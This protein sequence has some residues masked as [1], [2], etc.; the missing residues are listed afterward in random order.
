MDQSHSWSRISSLVSLSFVSPFYTN[1]A[2]DDLRLHFIV[3]L[4]RF[5]L[6]R[7]CL[8]ARQFQPTWRQL[9]ALA[10]VVV[11]RPLSG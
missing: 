10:V 9:C 2:P 7:D 5:D 1:L 11:P 8:L 4:D 3:S 6:L